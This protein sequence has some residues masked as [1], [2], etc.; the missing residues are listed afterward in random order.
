MSEIIEV[1]SRRLKVESGDKILVEQHECG[2]CGTHTKITVTRNGKDIAVLGNDIT[3]YGEDEIFGGVVVDEKDNVLPDPH[4]VVH[5]LGKNCMTLDKLHYVGL[6][7]AIVEGQNRMT[8][9][10]NRGNLDRFLDDKE[11]E[12]ICPDCRSKYKKDY[13]K[14]I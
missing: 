4:W 12:R 8:F 14:D 1:Q 2:K 3:L 9:L 11:K 7:G 6:C 13:G 10:N 5:I